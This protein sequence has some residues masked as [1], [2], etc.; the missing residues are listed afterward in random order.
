MAILYLDI[1]TFSENCASETSFNLNEITKIISIQYKKEN[2]PL[3]I[4]KEWVSGEKEILKQFYDDIRKMQEMDK[5]IIIV[6]HNLLRFDIPLLIQR[7]AHHGIDSMGNLNNLF[8]NTL[9]MDSMQCLLP[10]NDFRFKGLGAEDLSK[11]FGIRQPVHRNSQINE[12]YDKKE[13]SKIE[14]HIASDISFM[15][16]LW[17]KLRKSQ[18]ELKL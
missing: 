3:V 14:E 15:E 9:V 7:M 8:H 12:F 2:G 17:G 11:R 5:W 13:F 10:F 18:S 16:D 6:G 1:E 4:L